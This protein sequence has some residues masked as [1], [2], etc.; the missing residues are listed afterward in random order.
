[1]KKLIRDVTFQ[2]RYGKG[3]SVESQ[4]KVVCFVRKRA[5]KGILDAKELSVNC[6]I[7]IHYSSVSYSRMVSLMTWLLFL[8]PA[9][10]TAHS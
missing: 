3:K 4:S 7:P 10:N 9:I 6:S 2:S 8:S 1:M 5:S